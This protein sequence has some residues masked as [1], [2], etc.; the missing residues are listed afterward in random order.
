MIIIVFSKNS[1]DTNI[2]N[3]KVKKNRNMRI[4]GDLNVDEI[5]T[6]DECK[7]NRN[8]KLFQTSLIKDIIIKR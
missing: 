6:M 2:L 4:K 5:R 1:S 7:R 3:K 8:I